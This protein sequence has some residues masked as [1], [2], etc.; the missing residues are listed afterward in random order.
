MNQWANYQSVAVDVLLYSS[1]INVF[2]FSEKYCG[3]H[4]LTMCW[5][6][7]N[8]FKTKNLVGKAFYMTYHKQFFVK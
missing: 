5:G 7:K 4:Q 2:V 8:P 1:S 6:Q 3:K